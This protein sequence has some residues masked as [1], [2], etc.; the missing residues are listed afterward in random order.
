MTSGSRLGLKVSLAGDRIDF[1]FAN[2]QMADEF[3]RLNG[4]ER[5]A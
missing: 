3:A 4:A 5:E 2:D 1:L